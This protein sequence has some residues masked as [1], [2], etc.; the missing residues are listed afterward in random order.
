M[1]VRANLRDVADPGWL[2]DPVPAAGLRRLAGLDLCLDILAGPR[3]LPSVAAVAAAHPGLR[4]I[5][6]HAGQPPLGGAPSAGAFDLWAAS[7][8]RLA[9]HGNVAVK[10]SGLLSP[11]T[12]TG[13]LRPV[14]ETLLSAFGED[15]VM[16]GSDWPVCLLSASYR[17]VLA[18]A[19]AVLAGAGTG[20]VFGGN[21]RSGTASRPV[22]GRCL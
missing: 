8:R 9:G 16:F 18:A 15:R 2:S 3:A 6:N 5:V 17:D 10:F 19:R 21:A 1:G 13:H 7:I 11:T 14:A 22:N 12:G 4:L 20:R